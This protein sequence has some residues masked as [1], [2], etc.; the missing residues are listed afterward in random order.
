MAKVTRG[1][2]PTLPL[3][4][5]RKKNSQV[6]I[7][8]ERSLARGFISMINISDGSIMACSPS[9]LSLFFNVLPAGEVLTVEV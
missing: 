2:K 1:V 9:E 3:Y 5:E 7:R 6:Y 4:F 8:P